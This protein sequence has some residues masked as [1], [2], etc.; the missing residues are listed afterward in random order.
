MLM[1]AIFRIEDWGW[2]L[3]G[4]SRTDVTAALANESSEVMYPS[5]AVEDR[6]VHVEWKFRFVPRLRG[7]ASQL[8]KMD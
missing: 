4:F 5:F 2:I 7:S 6:N 8:P 3:K 1:D